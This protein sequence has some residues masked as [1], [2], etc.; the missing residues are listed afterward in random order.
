MISAYSGTDERA[1]AVA[2]SG[3]TPGSYDF[4]FATFAAVGTL[5]VGSGQTL[6]MTSTL[7]PNGQL[8][9]LEGELR[10]QAG[11]V[12][13]LNSLRTSQEVVVEDGGVLRADGC[14]APA[15]A[16]PAQQFADL[17]GDLTSQ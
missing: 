17:Q 16:P 10:V 6:T 12:L 5:N 13:I 1:I 4:S 8:A 9:L 2:L 14:L 7:A 3:A 11:A 15:I